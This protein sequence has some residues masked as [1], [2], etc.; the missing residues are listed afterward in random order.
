MRYVWV[1]R[2][3]PV[4]D[5]AAEDACLSPGRYVRFIVPPRRQGSHFA[6]LDTL[7]QV[8][9]SKC[10]AD[11]RA[12]YRYAEIRD[13]D[14]QTGDVV[15]RESKGYYLPT[16]RPAVARNGDVLISTVRTYRGGIGLVTDTG[17]NL[18]ASNA[19]LNL[20]DVTGHAPGVDLLYVY[21]FLRSDFFTEQA[22]SVL[23]RGLYPRMDKG[24]L[25]RILIPIP[26]GKVAARWISCLAQAIADKAATIRGKHAELMAAIRAEVCGE[27]K[28]ATRASR[29]DVWIDEI[30]PRAV[31]IEH[32]YPAA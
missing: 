5:I 10:K 17:D 31:N 6:P 16:G 24:A 13:I 27:Q 3:L 14:V 4:A 30:L 8:R 21:A 32:L 29:S 7:V 2:E 19:I 18:V 12:L 28:A 26:A 20:H 11:K 25:H 22:W 9:E 1:P 23:N 15:F